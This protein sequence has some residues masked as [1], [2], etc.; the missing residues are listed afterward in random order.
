[1]K[2]NIFFKAL[3]YS[4]NLPIKV[5]VKNGLIHQITPLNETL[6]ANHF[7]APG[8]VDLQINGFQGIDF[9]NENLTV[10]DVHNSCQILLNNGITSFLPTI[11]T[12]SDASIT[13]LVS[14]ISEACKSSSKTKSC[15]AG[16]HLEGPFISLE[17]GPKGAHS[18]E[19]IKAPN[20][21]LFIKWQK[22]A[23]GTI[24]IITLSPEWENSIE[25]IKKCVA[26]G[27]IVSIGHTAATSAQ[28]QNAIK[29][30]ATMSTHLGNACH[31]MLPRHENYVFEQLASDKLWSTIIADG[32]HLPNSLLKIFL[33]TKPNKTILVSD[34]T[35]FAGLSPGS[36]KSHIGGD[37]E[38]NK[39]GKLFMKN[40]PNM[41]AGSAQSLLWC[42]NQLIQKNILPLKDAWNM[43]SIK[44]IEALN[45]KNKNLL[46]VGNKADFVLFEVKNNNIEI[47]K[48]IKFGEVVFSTSN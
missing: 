15:I 44:P 38:L 14:T 23:N 26:S 18:K 36:Y 12:N 43:A 8:L 22:A 1:M 2:N 46:E 9:N 32:F 27:V 34:A 37:V 29:A 21:N 35:S 3:D 42:V 6:I 39:E 10:D 40:H 45:N 11:I 17:E 30:G 25:F 19:F 47:L 5:E 20:W 48:T 24:K 7:I 4:T 33:K 13:S 41:L 16:I 28:I 31:A